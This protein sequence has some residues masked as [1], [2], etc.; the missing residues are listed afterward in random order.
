MSL[1]TVAAIAGFVSMNPSNCRIKLTTSNH[2]IKC[3]FATDFHVM[4]R[5]NTGPS[6][7]V[8]R[9]RASICLAQSWSKNDL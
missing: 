8:P 2:G 6:S 4:P 5:V 7:L 3:V 9:T 1:M